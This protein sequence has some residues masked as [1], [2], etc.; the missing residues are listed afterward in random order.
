MIGHTKADG[1]LGRNHLL[2]SASDAM[3][4]LLVAVGHNLRLILKWPRLCMPWFVAALMS[5]LAQSD[6]SQAA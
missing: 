1:R 3:S 4:A 5:S 6:T 2:G